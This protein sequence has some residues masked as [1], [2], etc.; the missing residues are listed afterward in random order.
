MGSPTHLLVVLEDRFASYLA[1]REEG[2]SIPYARRSVRLELTE[3]QRA[4]IAPRR[5][6]DSYGVAMFES[7]RECWLEGSAGGEAPKAVDHA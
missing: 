2:Q 3:A 7:V 4:A 1:L 5:V 6:G